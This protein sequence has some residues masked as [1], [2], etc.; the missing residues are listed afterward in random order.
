MAGLLACPSAVALGLGVS[1]SGWAAF[2]SRMGVEAAHARKV[3]S[4]V[5][6][7]GFDLFTGASR[8]YGG[9]TGVLGDAALAQSVVLPVVTR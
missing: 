4:S 7:R 5:V 2:E 8:G 3:A 1:R 9:C 6:V